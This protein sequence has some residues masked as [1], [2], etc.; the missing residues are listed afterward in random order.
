M[1]PEE[2][3]IAMRVLGIMETVCVDFT[4]EF[5][6]VSA[7]DFCRRLLCQWLR[8]KVVCVG[9]DFR[10]GFERQGD[11]QVLKS[12]GHELGFRTRFVDELQFEGERVSSSRIRNLLAAGN[13]EQSATL[14]GAPYRLRGTVIRGR[15]EWRRL[16][17]PTANLQVDERK[18]TP[19]AGVYATRCRLGDVERLSVTNI[20]FRPTFGGGSALGIETHVPDFRRTIYGATM[21]IDFYA[22][23][24]DEQA[25]GSVGELKAAIAR[26][27]ERARQ[28]R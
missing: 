15:G 6:K 28:L 3:A 17:F 21:E 18:M 9:I 25:F 13:V 12:L 27:I 10:F 24:R 5:A 2:R 8:A 7:E 4:R 26:D 14:L 23:L 19:K 1:L 22:R 20:G 11:Q 16:G